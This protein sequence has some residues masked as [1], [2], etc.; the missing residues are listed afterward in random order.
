MYERLQWAPAL[1]R[2]PR[3]LAQNS[4]GIGRAVADQHAVYVDVVE[5]CGA[6]VVGSRVLAFIEDDNYS[7]NYIRRRNGRGCRGEFGSAPAQ[8]DPAGRARHLS[9]RRRVATNKMGHPV[10]GLDIKSGRAGTA[11]R[12]GA[13]I[14]AE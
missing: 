11:M 3:L 10:C 14:G 13:G 6:K 12:S 7:S 4:V 9:G 1:G 8:P 5:N 2:R